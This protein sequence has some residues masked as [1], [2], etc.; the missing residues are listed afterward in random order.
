MIFDQYYLDC[1]SHASYLIADEGTRRAVVVDPQR[2]ISEYLADAADKGLTIELVLET[3]FHADF[4]SGHLELASATGAEI[5]FSSVAEPEFEHRALADGERISLGDVVLEIRHTPGHTPESMSIVVW[6]HE[7]DEAPYAVLTGDTLFVGDVGR[8]D[9]LSSFGVTREE[10]G[11]MLY[12]SLHTKLLT[13]PDETRVYPAHGAGSAC[14]KNLSTD[15]WSTI[16]EQRD[17][18]YAIQAPDKAT[19][20]EVVTEG[21]PPAPAYFVHDAVLNRQAHDLLGEE[22]VPDGLDWAEVQAHRAAGALLVDGR[23]PVDFAR[24]HLAGAI[25]VGLEGRYAEFA[26]SIVPA[27]VDIVLF[28]EPGTE[29]EAKNRLGRIG[30]DRVVGYVED[31]YGV[32]QRHPGEVRQASRL[33]PVDFE[34]RRA[35]LDDLQL[36]DVRNPGEVALGTIPGAASIPVGQIPERVE[37]IDP[38]RPTVV[39]CAGGYRSSVAASLLRERGVADVSDILGGYGA[40]TTAIQPA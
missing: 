33:S 40:W 36:I 15:L 38:D 3:H 10:L 37:E 16:G 35:S 19:F 4:L 24:G 26:G 21:Q 22:V 13:L 18:N 1:L 34:E 17:T 5:G 14:G 11:E 8:P 27:D 31:P 20:I 29:L 7:D 9:L 32:L 30:F 12:E 39:Y 2:D 28:V 6:E 23:D 25:N